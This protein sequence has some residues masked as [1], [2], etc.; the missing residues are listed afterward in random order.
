MK[1]TIAIITLSLCLTGCQNQQSATT[2]QQKGP[3]YSKPLQLGQPALR[4][5]ASNNWPD[6]SAAWE[7]RD[8]FLQDAINN[9][10]RWFDAPSSKQ[11]FPKEGITHEQAKQ[12]IIAFGEALRNAPTK[13]AFINTLQNKFDM[14]QSVGYDG[15]GTVLF[16]GYYAPDFKASRFRTSEFTAPLYTRPTS[17]VTDPATGTPQGRKNTDG[18]TSQWPAREELIASGMLDGTELV[19]VKDELD[20]YIIHVNGSARLRMTDGTLMFIGY[21][22][23]TD[24]PYTGLGHLIVDAGLLPADQLSLRAI[25]RAYDKNPTQITNLINKNES[26]VFFQEYDGG[27]WPSGSLGVPVTPER[28]VATDK[29]I[30]PR[31]GVIFVETTTRSLSGQR[32]PFTQFMTDQDTGGAIRAPGRT[33]LYM[34]VGAIAGIKA[35][36]QYNEGNLYYFFLKPEAIAAVRD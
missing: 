18:T 16:T 10:I 21:A 7:S 32:K 26:F 22:G 30:F 9:S 25:R 17:L 28:S 8:L 29:N 34:G 36:G 1:Q 35:G 33:D 11:W 6:V 2:T 5:V 31:G 24:R 13:Q 23:K 3:N 19:W 20:A 27:N 15:N 12:S 14:Y 4:Q